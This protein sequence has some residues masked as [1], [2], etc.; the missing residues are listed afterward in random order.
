[1]YAAGMT[2][3]GVKVASGVETDRVEEDAGT[4]E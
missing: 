4:D 2:E 3:G 1:M